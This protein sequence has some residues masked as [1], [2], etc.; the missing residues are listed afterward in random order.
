MAIITISKG[1][2]KR[3]RDI[4]EKVAAK[5]GYAVIAREVLIEASKEFNIPSIKLIRAIHDAPSIL[6]KYTYGKEKY[7]AYI[8]SAILEHFLDDNVVYHGLAGHFFVKDIAH[9]LKVRI[10]SDLEDRVRIEMEDKGISRNEARRIIQKD[11]A[12]R[13]KWS[14]HLYGI[15]TMD[16]HL[17][18]LVI[19]IHKITVDDAV[20]MI[21][22]ATSLERFKKSPESES[23]LKDL[24][25]AARVKANLIG[26]KPDVE[27]S[28]KGGAVHV[29][30][31]APMSELKQLEADINSLCE[32]IRGIQGITVDIRPKGSMGI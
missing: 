2:Y 29:K 10:I 27:V 16:P 24:Y 15:D 21:C 26:L 17:Y 7:I 12:E 23:E 14:Q 30:T 20:D 32:C 3:G 4:A 19:H 8:Q 11:D 9:V 1:S 6:D 31:K 13:R 18:D 22:N 28:A 5:L 25:L